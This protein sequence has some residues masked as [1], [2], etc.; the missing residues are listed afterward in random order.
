MRTKALQHLAQHLVLAAATLLLAACGDDS[1][2]PTENICLYESA[3]CHNAYSEIVG[4]SLLYFDSTC[5]PADT[6]YSTA[7]SVIVEG[8]DCSFLERTSSSD[9]EGTTYT[10]YGRNAR[11]ISDATCDEW[12]ANPAAFM[13]RGETGADP[14]DDDSSDDESSSDGFGVDNDPPV[15]DDPGFDD[16]ESPSDPPSMCE[17]ECPATSEVDAACWSEGTACETITNCAGDVFACGVETETFDCAEGACIDCPLEPNDNPCVDCIRLKCCITFG[18]C[19]IDEE[20]TSCDAASCPPGA[21]S[22]FDNAA[23]CIARFCSDAC[24]L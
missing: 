7:C 13:S 9:F 17:V 23:L 16:D 24:D 1:D 15:D 2:G 3:E 4:D 21:N 11:F 14:L 12:S 22:E 10:R 5:P 8:Q 19:V 20:C 18:R 6:D